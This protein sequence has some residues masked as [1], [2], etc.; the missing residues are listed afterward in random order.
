MGIVI[1]P[2]RSHQCQGAHFS[3]ILLKGE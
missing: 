2:N 3:Y 1:A